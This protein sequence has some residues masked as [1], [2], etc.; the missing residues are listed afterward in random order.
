[1][2]LGYIE[3]EYWLEMGLAVL[4][5]RRF[6]FLLAL[7][8]ARDQRKI[9]Y[10]FERIGLSIIR[11]HSNVVW[12]VFFSF[13]LDSS[14]WKAARVYQMVSLQFYGYANMDCRRVLQVIF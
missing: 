4:W 6:F 9:E 8:A 10:C 2:L 5:L 14:W 3:I 13:Y 7:W 1:M 11:R 12:L